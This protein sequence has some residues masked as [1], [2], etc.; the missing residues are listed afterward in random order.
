[1]LLRKENDYAS[2]KPTVNNYFVMALKISVI[3]FSI[4]KED[5][6]CL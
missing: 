1:M 5:K 2:R 4:F 3:K 6:L